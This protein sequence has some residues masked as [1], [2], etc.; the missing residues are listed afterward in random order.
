MSSLLSKFGL[1]IKHGK[2]NIFH[3]SRAYGVFNPPS[4]NLSSIGSPLL[5]PKDTWRYLGFIFDYKLT[6]R[7]YINFYFNKVISTIK[8]MKLLGN[9]TR[10]INP[11]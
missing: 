2:T 4:L 7:N 1:I 9:S 10:G 11:I 5:L 3:F 6:F 8:C